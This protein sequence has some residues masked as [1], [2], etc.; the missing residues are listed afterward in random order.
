MGNRPPGFP[1]PPYVAPGTTRTGHNGRRH[2]PLWARV[3]IGIMAFLII[4]GGGA[5]AYYQ[6]NFANSVNDITGNNA[7][8]DLGGKNSGAQQPVNVDPLTQRTNIV[9]LGSDTD[10]KGNDIATGTPWLRP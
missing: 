5:F 6:I 2:I 4:T 3:V 1:A 8:H 7:L 9:L 10:G